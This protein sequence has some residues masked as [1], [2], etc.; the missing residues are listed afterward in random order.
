M[1]FENIPVIKYEG[2]E[3]KNPLAFKFYDADKIVIIVCPVHQKLAVVIGIDVVFFLIEIGFHA[4]NDVGTA[5]F[6]D[7]GDQTVAALLRIARTHTLGKGI[8]V[9]RVILRRNDVVAVVQ[10]ALI[11]L[12]GRGDGVAVHR[13]HCHEVGIVMGSDSDLPVMEKAAAMLEKFGIDY[14]RYSLNEKLVT[15]FDIPK[16]IILM[17]R[18]LLSIIKINTIRN[19]II[20]GYVVF[21]ILRRSCK[22]K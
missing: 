10:Y 20:Y 16:I 7:G 5:A 1:I 6:P 19:G 4:D 14:E 17:F 15:S 13:G 22:A 9:F 18:A 12:V 21:E 11:A 8:I 3:S 2:A